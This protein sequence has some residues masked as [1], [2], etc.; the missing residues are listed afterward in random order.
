MIDGDE[1]KNC[2]W[3]YKLVA[4]LVVCLLMNI[5]LSGVFIYDRVYTDENILQQ[6]DDLKKVREVTECVFLESKGK[7]SNY[8]FFKSQCVSMIGCV[9]F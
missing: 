2:D 9:E 3:Y 5:V 4:G 6:L 7:S 1:R 8:T